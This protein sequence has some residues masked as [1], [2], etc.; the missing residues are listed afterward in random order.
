MPKTFKENKEIK[1]KRRESIL[2]TSLNLFIRYGYESVS[3]DSIS[4]VL[5]CSH[6][7][8]YHYFTSKE[9][10]YKAIDENSRSLLNEIFLSLNELDPGCNLIQKLT[11]EIFSLIYKEERNAKLIAL[12][13]DDKLNKVNDGLSIKDSLL[14]KKIFTLFFKS[15]SII[16]KDIDKND[17]FS[18]NELVI[19]YFAF[20]KDSA[21]NKI[22]YPNLFKSKPDINYF[23][24]LI[25]KEDTNV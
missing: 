1:E 15:F 12:F 24:L 11:D 13:F 9:E 20:I 19:L 25:N 17:K 23:F 3:I 6:S 14:K 21:L 16:K 7:L 18:V 22:H 4:N 8:L 2:D 10:I 5:R